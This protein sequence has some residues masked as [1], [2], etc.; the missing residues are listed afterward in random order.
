MTIIN[1][2]TKTP[3]TVGELL[4]FWRMKADATRNM[5]FETVA[6]AYEECA[7]HLK[8]LHYF[9]REHPLTV[10]E[11]SEDCGYSTDHL[12]RLVQEGKISNVGTNGQVRLRRIDLPRKASHAGWEESDIYDEPL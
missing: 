10:E 6:R 1:T 7:K 3:T 4:N 9:Q 12:Y 2:T 8:A 5:G 11:A